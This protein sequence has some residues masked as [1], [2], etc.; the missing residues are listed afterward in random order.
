[1]HSDREVR[2]ELADCIAACQLASTLQDV[3][4]SLKV[5]GSVPRARKILRQAKAEIADVASGVTRL[6]APAEVMLSLL[7]VEAFE[8]FETGK[9]EDSSVFRPRAGS[10]EVVRVSHT[11]THHGF[12]RL[13]TSRGCFLGWPRSK[14]SLRRGREDVQDWLGGLSGVGGG[15][16]GDTV[17]P[18][19][20]ASQRGA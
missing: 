10:R 8:L 19:R 20:H 9:T 18:T 4:A 1:V 16:W 2:V 15:E 7:T 11:F 17:A 5:A 6:Q 14:A 12:R 13:Q 3:H